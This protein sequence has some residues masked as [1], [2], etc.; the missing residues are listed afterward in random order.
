MGGRTGT[1]GA[2]LGYRLQLVA[3]IEIR[4]SFG[5]YVC[6][7]GP[8][9]GATSLVHEPAFQ[10]ASAGKAADLPCCQYAGDLGVHLRLPR[11]VARLA[12]IRAR[13][14]RRSSGVPWPTDSSVRFRPSGSKTGGPGF[15]A[16]TLRSASSSAFDTTT[17]SMR[18]ACQ[19]CGGSASAAGPCFAP[20]GVRSHESVNVFHHFLSAVLL[21]TMVP[22]RIR[23]SSGI[24]TEFQSP[25]S[26]SLAHGRGHVHACHE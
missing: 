8:G 23:D 15:G 2:K 17:A 10:P 11:Q 4:S 24:A 25:S 3:E 26:I 16:C 21:G 1:G 7:P 22:L 9:F 6:R 19:S 14:S 5:S 12:W 20:C 13:R 18:A